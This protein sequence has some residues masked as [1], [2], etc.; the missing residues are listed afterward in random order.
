MMSVLKALVVP[1][2][3]YLRR[4]F[5]VFEYTAETDCLFRARFST[6][7]RDI[8]LPDLNV[9]AGDPVLEL[10]FWNEHFP[11]V[12]AGGPDIKWAV[13]GSKKVVTS[14]RLLAQRLEDDPK[15]RAV[16]AIGGTTPLF[17]AGEGSGWEK[18]FSRLGFKLWP[19]VNPAGSFAE[20]WENFYAWMVMRSFH[21]GSGTSLRLG[22]I[23]R[24]DFWVSRDEFLERHGNSSRS[25]AGS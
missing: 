11:P 3:R 25:E 19:H 17:K 16:S 13:N 14:C 24:T 20:F 22:E 1:L 21:V 12:P 4:R 6:A 18:M 23:E 7:E 5:G 9:P 10:H 15:M 8:E 2:D